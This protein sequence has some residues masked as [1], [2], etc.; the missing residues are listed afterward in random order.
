MCIIGCLHEYVLSLLPTAMVMFC[1]F[2]ISSKF[3][4]NLFLKILQITEK[5]TKRIVDANLKSC[6]VVR[7]KV[8]SLYHMEAKVTLITLHHVINALSFLLINVKS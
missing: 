7:C 2:D 8:G 3:Y 5:K 4:K 1:L 6:C